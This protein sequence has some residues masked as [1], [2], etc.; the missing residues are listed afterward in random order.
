MRS[1]VRHVRSS[2]DSVPGSGSL[3][4]GRWTDI[5]LLARVGFR[6]LKFL[7][8][9]SGPEEGLNASFVS[10]GSSLAHFYGCFCNL[11]YIC[12]ILPVL[13]VLCVFN[14]EAIAASPFCG[15][16]RLEGEF[17]VGRLA[18]GG[19][20]FHGL[21]SR[22]LSVVKVLSYLMGQ[23]WSSFDRFFWD[24]T[25]F[26][27]PSHSGHTEGRRI[28]FLEN[29]QRVCECPVWE[30]GFGSLPNSCPYHSEVEATCRRHKKCR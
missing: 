12:Y 30:T 23:I 6:F 15:R 14:G 17:F 18:S 2:K 9:P 7:S 8:G 10:S 21:L 4:R 16:G 27:F 3:F 11:E 29:K 28:L 22:G 1:K 19:P 25:K 20:P 5:G 13:C 26:Y 24:L